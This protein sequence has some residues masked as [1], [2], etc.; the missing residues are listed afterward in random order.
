MDIINKVSIDW[1]AVRELAKSAGRAAWF[2]GLAVVVAYLEAKV[3]G[4]GLNEITVIG[5]GFLLK[6]IDRYIHKSKN[7]VEN[8][9]APNFLQ[10]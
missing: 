2:A 5:V 4:G 3:S 6:A 10:R 8:G 1:D 9:I 7:T